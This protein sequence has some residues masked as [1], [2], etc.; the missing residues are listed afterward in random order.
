MFLDVWGIFHLIISLNIHS[1]SHYKNFTYFRRNITD[2][3]ISAANSW[4][5]TDLSTNI[6]VEF[7]DGY[8]RRWSVNK[9]YEKAIL[10]VIASIKVL[11]PCRRIMPSVNPSVRASTKWLKHFR[12][13]FPRNT[14]SEPSST[15]HLSRSFIA[16]TTMVWHRDVGLLP[17]IWEE[18]RC[19]R[20]TA[21]EGVPFD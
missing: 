20:T 9:W 5:S 16:I 14:H 10:S 1:F 18:G 11:N 21:T 7:T 2:G 17:E 8:F 3:S 19:P 12:F 6:V 15:E 13:H 4:L